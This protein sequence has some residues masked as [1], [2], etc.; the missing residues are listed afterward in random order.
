MCDKAKQYDRA[1]EHALI[2][3]KARKVEYDADDY[4]AKI[5]RLKSVYSASAMSSLPRATINS[6]LPVFIV[7]MPRSGT[8]LLEQILSCHT[9]IHA[10]GETSDVGNVAEAIPYYPDGVRNLTSQR[11][12][13]MA[14]AYIGRLVKM[15]P[16]ATRVTDKLPGNYLYLGFISQ[17]FPGAKVIHCLRDP[18]DVCLSNYFTDFNIGHYYSSDLGSLARHYR[19]YRD[20]MEHW[21]AVLPI[22]ILE[23]RYEDLV[24]N[25]R[26]WTEKILDFCGLDWEEA[27]LD[28]HKSRRRVA[29]ASYDQVR[30]PLY[31]S[32]I[33]RWKNYERHLEPVSRI[34]GLHG[35]S[36]T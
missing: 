33:A 21:K 11:L 22:L 19:T 28:F 17:L 31:K 15:A 1:F 25:P 30:N 4:A 2:A 9:K 18:R 23:V 12:D 35:D 13:A 36:Y 7:G 20:L 29:T 8:S 26:E 27:C 32:S 34:L 10:R 5:S 24:D 3:N 16:T 6:E 14:T